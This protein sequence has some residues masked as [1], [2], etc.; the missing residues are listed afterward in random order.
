MNVAACKNNLGSAYSTRANRAQAANDLDR[1]IAN[2]ELALP[3]LREAAR[4]FR[5]TNHV[6]R[7]DKIFRIAVNVEENIRRIRITKEAEA[8]AT[9]G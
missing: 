6:D 2:L 3:H 5:A 4:I 7:A 8:A 1:C 9:R